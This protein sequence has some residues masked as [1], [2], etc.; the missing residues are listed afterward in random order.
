MRRDIC[1]HTSKAFLLSLAALAVGA[2]PLSAQQSSPALSWER[3]E[4]SNGLEVVFLPDSTQDEVAVEL[5]TRA[6]IRHEP[7]GRFGMAHFF[8]HAL[9]HGAMLRTAVRGLAESLRTGSNARTLYDYTR[10]YQKAKRQGLELFL[11]M[12]ADRLGS[13]PAFDLTDDAIEIQRERVLAEMERQANTRWG[14]PVRARLARGTFGAAHP[15]GHAAYGTAEET[16]LTTRDD[17]VRWHRGHVRPEY[18]TLFVAGG[19]DPVATRSIVDVIFGRI[20]GGTRPPAPAPDVPTPA[21][22]RASLQVAA[23]ESMLFL[24]WPAPEWASGDTPLLEL[25]GHVLA[26]RLSAD[27]PA[28]VLR[29]SVEAEGLELAGSFTIVVAHEPTANTATLETWVRD[30]LAAAL[31]RLGQ[32]ELAAALTAEHR[33]VAGFMD[34]LG[35][36]GGRIELVGES[37]IFSGNPGH[38]VDHLNLQGRA[39]PDDVLNVARRWLTPP[40]FVLLVTGT[41]AETR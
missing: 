26:N 2:S 24:A 41:R 14:E 29:S 6:G 15:Y 27:P 10:Y 32:D 16:R 21:G 13:D 30:A 35:W 5:W 22:G 31:Q 23:G 40:A 11:L 9:P 7:V 25:F 4:L 38:Y 20:P 8:E 17:L 19:F 28:G 18:S 39:Q 3:F 37:L 12:A 1:R 36:I 33:R 34:Q